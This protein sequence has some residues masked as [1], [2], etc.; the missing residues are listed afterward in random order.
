MN[1][2][3]TAI[4]FLTVLPLPGSNNET[5]R[6]LANSTLMFPVAGLLIGG[7]MAALSWGLWAVLPPTLAAVV[8]VA[9]LI[10]ISGGLHMDGLSD[11]A[12][13]FFSSRPRERILEI[14]KDSRVGAMGVIAIALMLLLKTAAFTSLPGP[15]VPKVAFLAPACGR[16]VLV[17]GINL[18][19]NARAEGG[20]ASLFRTGCSWRQ[21]VL[22]TI[23]ALGAGWFV[24]HRAGLIAVAI[25]LFAILGFSMHCYRKIGGVTGDTLGAS[26]ELAEAAVVLAVATEPLQALV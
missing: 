7:V 11:T 8:L 26:C 4:R 14:M 15:L 20:L 24:L 13:G 22:A 12:D 5:P 18:L 19:P 9:C 2:L 17:L 6:D 23:V 21:L 1:R 3:L 10:G 25:A 16:C